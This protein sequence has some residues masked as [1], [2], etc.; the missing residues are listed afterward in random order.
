MTDI[1]HG[2]TNGYVNHKCRCDLCRRAWADYMRD[3][4]RRK[5]DA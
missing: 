2:T 1:K 5:K 4:R 3:L